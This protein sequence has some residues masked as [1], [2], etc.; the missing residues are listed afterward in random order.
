MQ[1]QRKGSVFAS[2]KEEF[3]MGEIEGFFFF[4]FFVKYLVKLFDY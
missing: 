1:K 4:F 2:E 3:G